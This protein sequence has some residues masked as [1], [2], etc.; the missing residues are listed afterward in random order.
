MAKIQEKV[1]VTRLSSKGQIVLPQG[2]RNKMSLEEGTAFVVIASG[3]TVVLKKLEMP[4]LAGAQALLYKSR[5]YAKKAKISPRR[6]RS[7]IH[8]ARSDS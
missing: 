6:I 4:S 2:I 3:D 8:K 1:E 7:A 5:A